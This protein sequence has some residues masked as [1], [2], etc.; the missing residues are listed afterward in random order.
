MWRMH[1]ADVPASVAVARA[2]TAVVRRSIGARPLLADPGR[3]AR[4]YS[5]AWVLHRQV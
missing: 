5:M 4:I 3:V 1:Q 2:R